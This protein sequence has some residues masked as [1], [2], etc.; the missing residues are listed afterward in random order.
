M[1]FIKGDTMK[2]TWIVFI[3]DDDGFVGGVFDNKK[4]ANAC[5][6]YHHSF[7]PLATYV[8]KINLTNIQSTFTAP[9]DQ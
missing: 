8:L 3:A 7:M 5:Y 6:K 2:S 9:I 1:S 4:A